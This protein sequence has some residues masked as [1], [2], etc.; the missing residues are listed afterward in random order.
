MRKNVKC[1]YHTNRKMDDSVYNLRREVMAIIYEMKKHVELPR[2]DIRITDTK[3][4]VLG[5]ARMGDNM[6][7]IPAD[8]VI[9]NAHRMWEVVLHEILHAVK[10]IP[11]DVN[12]K[13]MSP[14][15]GKGLSKLQAIKIFKTYYK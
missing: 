6:I 15:C 12:C 11:H 4:N 5:T 10:A 1:S 13:L 2:I 14:T 7:W 3:R 8:T 9:N